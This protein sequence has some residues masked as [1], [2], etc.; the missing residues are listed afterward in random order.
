M[1]NP[2]LLGGVTVRVGGCSFVFVFGFP[3]PSSVLDLLSEG[4]RV[5]GK[6]EIDLNVYGLNVDVHIGQTKHYKIFCRI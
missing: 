6:G 5:W 2:E 4:F 3:S 1:K